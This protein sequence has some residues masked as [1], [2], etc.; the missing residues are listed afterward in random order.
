VAIQGCPS[1]WPTVRPVARTTVR[2]SVR[3]R[4]PEA[5]DNRTVTSI[6]AI[7]TFLPPDRVTVASRLRD[8]GQDET[9]IRLFEHFYGF[10]EIRLDVG[11]GATDQLVAAVA[12]LRA[13]RGR[14]H[15]VRY[16]LYARSMPVAAPYPHNPLRD[17]CRT[18]GLDAATAFSVSQHA[19]ASA[20]LAIDLAD[21]LLATSG[22]P[23]ALALVLAGDKTFTP[24]A[25]AVSS[26]AVMGEGAA[27]VLVRADGERDRMMSYATRTHGRYADGPWMSPELSTRFQ[28]EYPGALAEVITGAVLRAG[29]SLGQVALILPHN[30]N[31]MSWMRVLRLLGI[32]DA[33]RLYLANQALLGHCFCADS[34]LNYESARQAGRLRPGDHYVMTAVGLGATFSAM[35]F[36]H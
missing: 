32:R 24:A 36:T 25:Q 29:L 11:G 6:E 31:R 35:V 1:G 2:Q 14:E 17:A 13:L 7:S 9:H 18:L 27:A 5:D 10:A 22:D 3:C 26:A 16:V 33:S 23:D 30:V 12:E 19:C 28:Q 8:L 20:L 15:Q 34:F 4:R 21:K